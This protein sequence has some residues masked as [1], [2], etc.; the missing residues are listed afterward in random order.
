MKSFTNYAN[1][2]EESKGIKLDRRFRK[3]RSLRRRVSWW[4]KVDRLERG[5][6]LNI[7]VTYATVS[8]IRVS[9]ETHWRTIDRLQS[10][11]CTRLGYI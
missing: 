6:D 5:K 10:L 3:E 4:R 8:S 1:A 2:T 9:T 11:E 7:N